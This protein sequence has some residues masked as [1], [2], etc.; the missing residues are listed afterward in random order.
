MRSMRSAARSTHLSFVFRFVAA[1]LL[2]GCASDS[3]RVSPTDCARLRDH[4]VDLRMQSV[5]ADHDQHRAALRAAL[6]ASFLTS[7]VELTTEV[8]LRCALRARDAEALGACG[9]PGT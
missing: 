5:T 2:T 6:G 1:A 4:L 8:Q 7:C 3:G 9:E